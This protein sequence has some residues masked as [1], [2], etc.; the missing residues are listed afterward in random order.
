M[1]ETLFGKDYFDVIIGAEEDTPKKP[2]P[3]TTSLALSKLN[4]KSS[5]AIFFGDSDV[6]I[7]TAK[8]AQ[9]KSVGCSWGFRSIECLIS[10]LPDVIINKPADIIKLF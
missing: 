9:I 6:D 3:Y 5:E 2:D 1:V 4:C 10:A 8:N 7:H